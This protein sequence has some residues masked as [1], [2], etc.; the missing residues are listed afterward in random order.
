M[1]RSQILLCVGGCALAIRATADDALSAGTRIV[2]ELARCAR[3]G[4]GRV[5]VPA[6][7][8][9]VPPLTLP[10]NTTLHLADG[11]VLRGLAPTNPAALITARGATNI[12]IT[13]QG[14]IEGQATLPIRQVRPLDPHAFRPVAHLSYDWDPAVPRIRHLLLFEACTN[15]H[16]EGVTLRNAG[17]WT[18]R[19]NGCRDVVVRGVTIRNPLEAPC[20]D[21]IDPCDT[22][23]V[24][25]ERCD[26]ETADD[27]ICF[28]SMR[29]RPMRNLTVRDCRLVTTCNAIKVGTDSVGEVEDLTVERCTVEAMP[30]ANVYRCISGVALESVD[31]G[32]VRRIRVR[33]M[34]IRYARNALFI[35]VGL[36]R[37]RPDHEPPAPQQPG[38]VEDVVFEEIRAEGMRIGCPFV[39]M[40]GQPVRNIVVR[41]VQL[42][43]E[44]GR[45]SDA[46]PLRPPLRAADYPEALMWG[47]LPAWAFYLRHVDGLRFENVRIHALC[48]DGRPPLV[49]D[50]AVNVTLDG[51]RW[52]GQPVEPRVVTDA[53]ASPPSPETPK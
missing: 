34:N 6:G 26:I 47:E 33:G 52:D 3:E 45:S 41:D 19:L 2:A 27:A 28:K 38:V 23:D 5:V 30:T 13:G 53:D 29:R 31:G 42:T 14:T 4:G 15:I 12:A 20:V 8:H 11:A 24:L 49:L 46:S 1:K 50:D 35:R 17:S 39:G 10:P 21:G 9:L 16:I 48:A 44:G 25:I 18:V 37:P 7:L 40:P 51:L 36:R 43:V 32:A 22:S